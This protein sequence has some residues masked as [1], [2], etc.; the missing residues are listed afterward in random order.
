MKLS[1]LL[2]ASSSLVLVNFIGATT[3]NTTITVTTLVDENGENPSACSLRE[4]I[5]ANNDV[6]PFGGCTPGDRYLTNTILLPK[7]TITLTGGVLKSTRPIKISGAD[8]TIMKQSTRSP[9]TPGPGLVSL[10]APLTAMAHVSWTP[11]AGIVA[12]S[13]RM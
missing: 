9:T 11:R 10:S 3:I 6:L 13:F 5:K 4:A 2:L 7:G 1:R 12:W 8:P